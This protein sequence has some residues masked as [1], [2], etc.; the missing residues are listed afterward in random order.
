MVVGVVVPLFSVKGIGGT[1][2]SSLVG[3]G[4]VAIEEEDDPTLTV[5]V[6]VV[7]VVRAATG[8]SDGVPLTASSVLT[9][10]VA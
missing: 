5:A 3:D 4:M 7:G 2:R 10:L 6:V 9:V 8:G 1:D